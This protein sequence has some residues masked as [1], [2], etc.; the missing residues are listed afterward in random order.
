MHNL[1]WSGTGNGSSVSY[2][3]GCSVVSKG[4]AD[5]LIIRWGLLILSWN[6]LKQLKPSLDGLPKSFYWKAYLCHCISCQ[7]RPNSVISLTGPCH[8]STYSYQLKLYHDRKIR[9][10]NMRKGLPSC[11]LRLSDNSH[12]HHDCACL[13]SDQGRRPSVCILASGR[14]EWCLNYRL[15]KI[16]CVICIGSNEW[17]GQQ[18]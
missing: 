16:I 11:H 14:P 13:W 4:H 10:S 9:A 15:Q 1:F 18:Q 3:C 8:I 2:S 12:C 7:L 5:I 6:S 17:Y